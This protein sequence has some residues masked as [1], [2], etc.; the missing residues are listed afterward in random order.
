MT[1]LV[2]LKKKKNIFKSIQMAY[3]I[4]KHNKVWVE[5]WQEKKIDTYFRFRHRLDNSSIFRSMSIW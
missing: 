4:E 3:S 2:K 1:I 5:G